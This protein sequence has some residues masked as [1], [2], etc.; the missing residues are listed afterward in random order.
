MSPNPHPEG[1]R[2]G[3]EKMEVLIRCEECFDL[4]VVREGEECKK[5]KECG[6][7]LPP[8]EIKER[9]REMKEYINLSEL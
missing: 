5:C 8:E 6:A 1:F 3:G 4:T 7:K 2:G 9:F